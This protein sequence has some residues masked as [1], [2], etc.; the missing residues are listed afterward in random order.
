ADSALAQKLQE[1]KDA[2]GDWHDW[3]E[4][5]DIAH[6]VLDHGASC[7]LSKRLAET[8][9]TKYRHALSLAQALTARQLRSRARKRGK[10]AAKE[11]PIAEP[12]LEAVTAIA[13]DSGP[14]VAH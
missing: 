2:I 4:L 14:E 13:E 12:V 5:T 11:S 9:E 6:D 8:R 7:A 10:R 1:V 3:V